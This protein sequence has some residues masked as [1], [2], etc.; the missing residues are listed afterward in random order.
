M[1]DKDDAALVVQLAQWGTMM[2]LD[3]ALSELFSDDFDPESATIDNHS[4]RRAL[5]FGETVG[6]LTKNGLIS[7]ELVLDWLWIS[8]VWE[9]VG[10][11]ALKQREKYGVSQLYENMEALAAKQGAPA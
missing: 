9:R 7:T 2:G 10:P 5:Q 8:G 1:P 11:A 4:V 3:Q 6:T